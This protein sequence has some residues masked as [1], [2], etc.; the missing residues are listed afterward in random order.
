[1]F[2]LKTEQ[3][4]SQDYS[5]VDYPQ[6]IR[7]SSMKSDAVA[8]HPHDQDLGLYLLERLPE[9]S[10]SAMDIHLA[11]CGTC[12][13]RLLREISSL[14]SS[15]V[16]QLGASLNGEMRKELRYQTNEIVSLQTL[17]PF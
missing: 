6:T 17:S 11:H 3:L 7:V 8:L 12:D 13:Q 10:V 5:I 2:F 14:P 1:M 9:D 16:G 15:E 4:P